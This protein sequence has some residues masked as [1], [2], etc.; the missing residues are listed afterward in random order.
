MVDEISAGSSVDKPDMGETVVLA[1]SEDSSLNFNFALSG[2]KLELRDIDLVLVFPDGSRLVAAELGLR[3]VSEPDLKL[4]FTDDT[5]DASEILQAVQT[6][7]EGTSEVAPSVVVAEP[8]GGGAGQAQAAAPTVRSIKVLR[9]VEQDRSAAETVSRDPSEALY[10]VERI[11]VVNQRATE[12]ALDTPSSRFQAIAEPDQTEGD[13][14][15]DPVTVSVRVLGISAYSRT[16]SGDGVT[17]SGGL[18]KGSGQPVFGYG[19]VSQADAVS[20]TDGNDVIFADNPVLAGGGKSTVLI[21]LNTIFS[22]T[23]NVISKIRVSGLPPGSGILDEASGSEMAEW[24]FSNVTSDTVSFKMR[25]SIPENSEEFAA[26]VSARFDLKVEYE[27][28]SASGARQSTSTLV[29]FAFRIVNSDDGLFE[30][31]P[32]GGASINVIW[33]NPPGT[34]VSTGSGDDYVVSGI[35][36]DTLDGGSGNDTVSYRLSSSGVRVNLSTKTTEGGYSKGDR[37][38]GFENIEG[39]SFSDTL[40][41]DDNNNIISGLGGP[42]T[43]VGG[44]GQDAVSYEKSE[45]GVSIDLEKELQESEGDANGD[46]LR[47]I[48]D[49]LGSPH[50][51]HIQGNA[52][53]NRLFGNAGNDTLI[54]GR[55]ADEI[56]GGDGVD[57]ASYATSDDGVRVDLSALGVPAHGGDADGD[58]LRS[59]ENLVGSRFNDVL[60]GNSLANYLHGGAGDDTLIGGGAG[61]TLSGGDGRDAAD[62]SNSAAAVTVDLSRTLPQFSLGDA[63]EDTLISIEDLVGSTRGDFLKGNGEANHIKGGAGN[64]TLAATSGDDTLDGEDGVDEVDFSSV[65]GAVALDLGAH[66]AEIYAARTDSIRILNVERVVGSN[67]NDTLIGDNSSNWISGGAGDDWLEGAGGLD[68]YA[69]GDGF[70]TLVFS[71]SDRELRADLLTGAV[72]L[73]SV[74]PVEE[75]FTGIEGVVGSRFNDVFVS[76]GDANFFDGGDGFDWV[77]YSLSPE[78]ITLDLERADA[79]MSKGNA[80][81]DRLVNIEGVIGSSFADM[82]SGSSSS[83]A[84]QGGV[85]DDSLYGLGGNDTLDG[86]YGNDLVDYRYSA[87]AVEVD[88]DAWLVRRANGE[89]DLLRDIER[90]GGSEQNDIF[91]AGATSTEFNGNFGTDTVDYSRSDAAV[92]V[93][94]KNEAQQNSGGYAYRDTL[95]SIEYLVGSNFNDV[96]LGNGSSNALFGGDGNDSLMGGQGADTLN[97][98]LGLDTASYTD[99]EAAVTVDLSSITPQI[100]QGTADG[101]LLVSIENLVGSQHSDVLIGDSR[102]NILEGGSGDDTLLGGGGADTLYGGEGQD[103]ASYEMSQAAVVVDLGLQLQIS[104]GDA[105]GDV[106]SSI[107]DLFGSTHSDLLLGSDIGNHLVGLAGDDTLIGRGGADTLDGGDGTDAVDYAASSVGVSVSLGLAGSQT[108]AGDADGDLLISIEN[109]FGSN[110]DDLLIGTDVGNHLAGRSGNDTLVGGGGADIL[111]GGTGSDTAGYLLSQLG[112]QVSLSIAGPQSSNGDASGDVLIEIENLIGSNQNDSLEGDSQAN[113]ILGSAGDD[114]LAGLAGEDTLIGG[115]GSDTASYVKSQVGVVVDLARTTAQVSPGDASGDVLSEIENLLGSNFDDSLKGSNE[116]NFLSGG[117]G[118]DTLQGLLGAD[119]LD[120]GAGIDTADY[121]LSSIGI[122]VDL[123][124]TLQAETGGA[125]GD[126][127]I[128]IENIVGTSSADSITGNDSDN[129]LVGLAGADTLSGGGGTDTVDYSSSDAAVSVDLRLSTGQI[130]LGHA[131]G[132]VL[133]SIEFIVGSRHSDLLIGDSFGNRLEGGDGNDTLSGLAGA[134]T[135]VGGAGEDTASYT[136]SLVAVTVDLRLSTAQVSSGDAS[137]DVLSGIEH[138]I[139]SGSGDRL[140]GTTA[141]NRLTGGSGNDT[142]VGLAGADTLAGDDGFD[143]AD[144]S[145]SSAA[146]TVDL[147]SSSAQIGGDAAGDQLFSIEGVRGSAQADRLTGDGFA[148]ELTGNAG[149]DTLIGLGGADTLDG[150]TGIDTVSYVASGAGITVNLASTTAQVSSG[151]ASGDVLRGIENVIG[152]IFA[153]R[154][155]GDAQANILAGLQ[156]ADTIDGGSGIDTVDYSLSSSSVTVLLDRSGPQVSGGDADGDVLLSIENILGTSQGDFLGGD[157]A[158]NQL[159]G[160]NGDDTLAGLAGA[161]RLDGGAGSDTADY[162]ASALGVTVDLRLSTAQ[163]SSGDASGDILV[164]VENV[165]GTTNSDTLTGSSSVNYLYGGAGNDVLDGGSGADFLFGGL[166]ADTIIAPIDGSDRILGGANVDTAKFVEAGT[167]VLT[168]L[169]SIEVLDFRNSLTNRVTINS[170]T[171][172]SL[173]PEAGLLTINRDA[174]D[175]ITLTGATDTNTTTQANGSTYQVFTMSNEDSMQIMIHL[176]V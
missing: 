8:H 55:G 115:N 67:F 41:G 146:V 110:L 141:A 83:N 175:I 118:N 159:F 40:L 156:G 165:I 60:I 100:S 101:D 19:A 22:D 88:A 21:E 38:E 154:L 84:I 61:D 99:S 126:T 69:G 9:L 16:S 131:N 7:S 174:S 140:I 105:D 39:S 134:D 136:G 119:T 75:R 37:I 30:R 51:D 5:L 70:D 102:S 123:R 113:V 111:D 13:R 68:E 18:T 34:D 53:I 173:S 97:G 137:G 17:V 81:G 29:P 150:G 23:S 149:N 169:F 143:I 108:S 92:S 6:F 64:D 44:S 26:S 107:E 14:S 71:H 164:G 66:S 116:D 86:G 124:N 109:L 122:S 20:G 74:N 128:D 155:T 147:G 95:I 35:G 158:A 45:A 24:T 58:I 42:D 76:N 176:Q 85:G 90:V 145:L 168:N 153:D 50:A 133:R 103:A 125:I 56:D 2:V 138:L 59:I 148:N 120:G 93:D 1:P 43:I 33:L 139:G 151:D 104:A 117:T 25:Y 129:V 163:I 4:A 87:I 32:T 65:G 106:L 54:G 79:Q 135:L 10:R 98:G 47:E 89:I 171:L 91:I 36:S 82:I 77:D 31:D 52:D 132:D 130:S 57:T 62:Y 80:R 121:S 166:G 161:D 127:L 49:V 11:K 15:S 3:L 48:E 63:S 144:Y 46:T 114:L 172:S 170:S 78:E 152:S 27:Y 73:G 160:G 112:V 96:L 72:Q 94:L 157:S 162:S 12:V 142:L 167:A 28:E